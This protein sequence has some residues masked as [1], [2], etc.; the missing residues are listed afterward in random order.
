M[1]L[2]KDAI[3]RRRTNNSMAKRKKRTNNDVQLK[4]IIKLPHALHMQHVT[5]NNVTKKVY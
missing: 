1:D 2:R 4:F 5:V 3:I